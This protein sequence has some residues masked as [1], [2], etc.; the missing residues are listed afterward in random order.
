MLGFL[1]NS[2][3]ASQEYPQLFENKTLSDNYEIVKIIDGPIDSLYKNNP[4]NE[5]IAQSD[6]RLW[7][8]NGNGQVIDYFSSYNLYASGLILEKEGFIDWIFTGNKEIKPYGEILDAKDYS[9]KKLFAAFDQADAIEF[10]DKDET[11][12]AYVYHEGQVTILDIS[13]RR[14][15]IDDF[16]FRQSVSKDFN[17]RREETTVKASRF[18]QY[19]Q[20]NPPVEFLTQLDDDLSSLLKK[21][22]FEKITQHK[23]RSYTETFLENTLGRLLFGGSQRQY[24]YSVGYSRYQLTLNNEKLKFSIFSGDTH[25]STRAWNF[26]V[27][28]S[29][30]QKRDLLFATINYRRHYLEELNEKSLLP[31]YEQDVG[32]YAVR[33]KIP[34]NQTNNTQWQLS[35]SGLHSYSSI[36]GNIHF[37]KEELHPVY[38]WFWKHFENASD[39]ELREAFGRRANIASPV[40]KT[41][42]GSITINRT[43][44]RKNGS[45]R[46]VVNGRDAFFFDKDRDVKIA[47][48]LTFDPAELTQA[49]QK[50][51]SFSEFLQL[52]LHA[53][54]KP[55]GA[56]LF[57][58]LQNNKQ[59]IPLKNIHF[60]YQEVPYSPK[61]PDVIKDEQQSELFSAYD[62]SLSQLNPDTLLK[63]LQALIDNQT[64][65]KYASSVS[66][67]LASLSYALNNNRKFSENTRLVNFYLD[68][69]HSVVYKK[70]TDDLQ[71]RNL[72]ILASQAVYLGSNTG[73]KDLND[74]IANTFIEQD[75]DL[76]QETNRVFLFNMACYY[77]VNHNKPQMLK[78]INR[79]TELG[80]MPEEFLKD[81]DFTD[82]LQDPEFLN[83]IGQKSAQ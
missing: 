29:K 32:L 75:F 3:T 45:F 69:V 5:Y 12:L 76:T 10:V 59:R 1:F 43:E 83:A 42:P 20:K 18:E 38:Y 33:K 82:Y 41:I 74:R 55:Y 30:N 17:L 9:E 71:Y 63:K 62:T 46:L 13:N 40:L 39:E 16:Y 35:Y 68:K 7:K 27:L 23:V 80:K 36:W 31:Y 81:P 49:F 24:S 56:E 15:K 73:N 34:Q 72:I 47:I 51:S 66:Y 44:F 53:E 57:V 2:A 78:L 60:D 70:Q 79:A 14:D 37:T 67:Y 22:G 64:A 6:S 28:E 48:T 11:G 50:I 21:V 61:S 19:K 8:I 58:H 54:E 25:D 4:S 26:R 52:N 65:S 77:A